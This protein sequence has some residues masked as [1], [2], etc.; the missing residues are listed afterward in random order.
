M[1]PSAWEEKVRKARAISSI[2]IA[3][4]LCALSAAN[5]A[6]Q[7]VAGS[8][9]SGIV[10]DTSGGALHGADVKITKTDTQIDALIPG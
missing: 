3:V 2:C 8:Q 9:V 5:A 4:V 1:S 6:A 10:R 7:A